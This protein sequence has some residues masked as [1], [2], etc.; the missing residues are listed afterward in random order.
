MTQKKCSKIEQKCKKNDQ[1]VQFRIKNIMY[2]RI[3]GPKKK[4]IFKLVF[5][6]AAMIK[7]SFIFSV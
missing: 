7:R 1:N 3:Y 4:Y 6:A 5:E 2:N